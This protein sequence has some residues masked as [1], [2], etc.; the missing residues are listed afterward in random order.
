MYKVR[1]NGEIFEAE[2][3]ENLLD[4]IKKNNLQIENP[5]NGL[6]TCGKCKVK[7]S[8]ASK[9]NSEQMKFLN[10]MDVK[11]NI[12]L[13]CMTEV[14][15]DMEVFLSDSEKEER[16]LSEG[17]M[18]E[19]KINAREGYGIA[20]DI[21]T[22]TIVCSLVDL[23]T[24]EIRDKA[25]MVNPQKQFGL[26][27]L[28]RITYNIEMGTEGL[29]KLQ[30]S[31]IEGLN[32]LL[33]EIYSNNN[34]DSS[35]ISE[36][37]VAANTTMLHILLG[38]DTSSLGVFPYK[39]EFIETRKLRAE[40]IGLDAN[41]NTILYT[42]PGVSAFIGSDIVSGVY[43]T[44]LYEEEGN[45]LFIDIG[46]NGEIVLKKDGDRGQ[47]YLSCCSCA[48]G[49]ALEGM[50]ITNGVRAGN[51]AIE[52]LKIKNDEI[53]IITI[54]NEKASGICGSGIL[55]VIRELV[56]HKIITTS[57]AIIKKDSIPEDDYRQ[58][59]ISLNGNKREF[60][61]AE[62]LGLKVTQSD[63]RQVQLAKGA[64]LSGFVAL[65]NKSKLNINE[66]DKIIIAGQFG[67][68]L[69]EESLI[70]SGILPQEC[71]NKISYVG[72]TSLSGAC[73]FLT[74]KDARLEMDK[75]AKEMEYIELGNTE[76]YEKIFRNSMMFPVE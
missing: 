49:P 1:I 66:L 33:N 9:V 42:L 34:I 32:T 30:R 31:V 48:A 47:K 39:P 70:K 56:K 7:L 8:V 54:N 14:S 11:N 10:D 46:T 69:P 2:E 75:L 57:G 3:S 53:D 50:N 67:A 24:G 20:V 51:G 74:S 58:K 13:A 41:E 6:G 19:Y 55:A 43:A 65:L 21:G 23:K 26:D 72:N 60:V 59:Y 27:V 73:M 44:G 40:S 64:I 17:F 36:I 62:E 37:V 45:I 22:T 18:R 5:C 61:I 29:L 35:E 76:N 71:R 16:V 4:L 68:H 28:S 25:S 38:S 63:I 52:D 15:S 12:R